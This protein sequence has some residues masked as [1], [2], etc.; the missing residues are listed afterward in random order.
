MNRRRCRLDS[1]PPPLLLVEMDGENEL[2]LGLVVVAVVAPTPGPAA[3]DELAPA[4][5]PAPAPAKICSIRAT[6]TDTGVTC[7][8]SMVGEMGE[9]RLVVSCAAPDSMFF[10]E[11]LGDCIDGD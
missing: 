1:A 2:E 5:A 10:N 6:A 11:R 9:A 4:L 3:V 8:W 7:E